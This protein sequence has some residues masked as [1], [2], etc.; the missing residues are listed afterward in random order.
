MHT[1]AWWEC[2][3]SSSLFP[4]FLLPPPPP[5]F[6]PSLAVACLT[7]GYELYCLLSG[8]VLGCVWAWLAEVPQGYGSQPSWFTGNSRA[9]RD[10][11]SLLCRS[12]GFYVC[13]SLSNQPL[14]LL[15]DVSAIILLCI[16]SVLYHVFNASLYEWIISLVQGDI[17]LFSVASLIENFWD[18]LLFIYWAHYSP[19]QNR[20]RQK[21]NV[22]EHHMISV[23]SVLQTLQ[24]K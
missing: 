2:W 20:S 16:V 23:L 1:H 8:L 11:P 18:L 19:C 10:S 5:A 13:S 21:Q 12:K 17:N 9:Q 22:K 3:R 7:E 15:S 24:K 14:A 4:V 6:P